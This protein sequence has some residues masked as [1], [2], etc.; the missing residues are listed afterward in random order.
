MTNTKMSRRKA[1]MKRSRRRVVF[2]L[3][4]TIWAIA[5]NWVAALVTLS[6][7]AKGVPDSGGALSS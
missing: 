5:T 1:Q 4:E 7:H 3:T 2:A 6:I